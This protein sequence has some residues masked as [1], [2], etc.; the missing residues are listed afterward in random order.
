MCGDMSGAARAA[1]STAAAHCMRWWKRGVGEVRVACP[2]LEAVS[3]NERMTHQRMRSTC[4]LCAPAVRTSAR[5]SR[6]WLR[7]GLRENV[8]LIQ[9][10]RRTARVRHGKRVMSSMRG[11]HVRVSPWNERCV[12]EVVWSRVLHAW[13]VR[14]SSESQERQGTSRDCVFGKRRRAPR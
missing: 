12:R 10:P 3:T 11:R 2:L 5:A 6:I 13:E 4:W 1:A 7:A 8:R 14:N 9:A